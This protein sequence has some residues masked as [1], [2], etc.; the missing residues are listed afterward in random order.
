MPNKF[1]MLGMSAYISVK[2]V[3]AKK[4]QV[5]KAWLL[6]RGNPFVMCSKLT[7]KFR[8]LLFLLF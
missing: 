1:L 7:H 8:I 5:M 6:T 4:E 2:I 3:R